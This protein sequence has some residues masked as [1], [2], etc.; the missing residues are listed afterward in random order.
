MKTVFTLLS[1]LL[2]GSQAFAV[3]E[4]PF[5]FM[6]GGKQLSGTLAL[7]EGKG[8]FPVMVM[9][10]SAELPDRDQTFTV[11]D[12]E[13]EC[14]YPTLQRQ[15]CLIFKELSD[16]FT[17]MGIAVLRYDKSTMKYTPEDPTAFS[18]YEYLGDL[19]SAIS[20]VKQDKSIDSTVIILFGFGQGGN[21]AVEATTQ[22]KDIDYLITYA[23]PMR[24]IEESMEDKIATS[25]KRCGEEEAG[26]MQKAIESMKAGFAKVRIGKLEKDE[27][28]GGAPLK[29]W[30]DLMSLTE[31]TAQRMTQ[32]QTPMLCL[33]GSLD[34]EVIIKDLEIVR[35]VPNKNIKPKVAYGVNHYMNDQ[36]NIAVAPVIFR[37]CDEFLKAQQELPE[38]EE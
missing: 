26:A 3:I 4:K 2:F 32:L 38:E 17:S 14:L 7:P 18:P 16:H 31:G 24:K 30:K 29:Y 20:A 8:P 6:S 25:F 11:D 15:K 33:V 23:M 27:T 5:N 10:H 13:L 28:V 36:K 12:P 35:A 21:L 1:I 34:Y 37:L 19:H 22:R 9:V